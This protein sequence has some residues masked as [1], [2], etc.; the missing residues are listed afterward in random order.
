MKNA[1]SRTLVPIGTLLAGFALGVL[2]ASNGASSD[3]MEE[4]GKNTAASPS[5]E[6]PSYEST[7]EAPPE[8]ASPKSG[9]V[10]QPTT[11]EPP[12]SGG[13][14][15]TNRK[16][17]ST[18]ESGEWPPKETEE[19]LLNLEEFQERTLGRSAEDLFLS[20]VEEEVILGKIRALATD[21]TTLIRTLP[22]GNRSRAEF[23]RQRENLKEAYTRD[24]HPHLSSEGQDL[25]QSLRTRIRRLAPWVLN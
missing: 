18:G 6:G 3:S 23:E 1:L 9:S 16:A 8:T 24:I 21:A 12:P 20:D 25:F 10:T 14:P 17:E 5:L 22:D 13:E 4:A 11:T 2:Y 19:L 7:Q 15:G